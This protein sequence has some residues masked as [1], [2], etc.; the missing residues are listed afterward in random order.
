MASSMCSRQSSTQTN[1]VGAVNY[2]MNNIVPEF[3]TCISVD[4]IYYRI[5]PLAPKNKEFPYLSFSDGSI[6][7]EEL[8]P[9]DEGFLNGN[10]GAPYQLF[11]DQVGTFCHSGFRPG[12][13]QPGRICAE[14]CSSTMICYSIPTPSILRPPCTSSDFNITVNTLSKQIFENVQFDGTNYY[15]TINQNL[16]YLI[17]RYHLQFQCHSGCRIVLNYG[18][19]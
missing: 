17:A 9:V 12:R 19:P 16:S 11:Q 1:S 13:N 3:P 8:H 15:I 7:P 2:K 14:V 6:I 18:T 5:S 4:D 10:V